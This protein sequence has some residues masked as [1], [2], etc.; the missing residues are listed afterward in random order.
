MADSESAESLKELLVNLLLGLFAI[1]LFV[2]KTVQV[3]RIE[4]HCVFQCI[5]ACGP[6]LH[7]FDVA[8][9][10]VNWRT[11]TEYYFLEFI[12]NFPPLSVSSKNND[13]FTCLL[14]QSI[15][16]CSFQKLYKLFQCVLVASRFRF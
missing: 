7:P 2:I 10:Y 9:F 16:L 12:L 15:S 13:L 6:A 5:L 14:C 11:T 3:S 4:L 8:N 1:V